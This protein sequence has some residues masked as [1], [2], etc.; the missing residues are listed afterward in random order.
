MA[1][2]DVQPRSSKSSRWRPSASTAS[3]RAETDIWRAS[4]ASSLTSTKVT[5]R[6]TAVIRAYSQLRL[7]FGHA[8]FSVIG[9]RFGRDGRGASPDRRVRRMVQHERAFSGA[10]IKKQYC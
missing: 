4:A 8:S 10:T 6:I 7:R 5:K 9:K 1:W 2:E 3:W